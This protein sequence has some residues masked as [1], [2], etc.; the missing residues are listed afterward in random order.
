MNEI[1]LYQESE[2]GLEAKFMDFS[3]LNVVLCVKLSGAV[4][5]ETG[6]KLDRE[7][8]KALGH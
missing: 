2:F 1:K 7:S 5:K 8:N 6:L 3:L 4:G